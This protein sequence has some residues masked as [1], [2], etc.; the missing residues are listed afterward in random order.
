MYGNQSWEF[1]CAYWGS[2]SEEKSEGFKRWSFWRQT[3]S[4]ALVFGKL[5][6]Q[7]CLQFLY[8]VSWTGVFLDWKLKTVCN[9]VGKSLLNTKIKNKNELTCFYY[10]NTNE[11]LSELSH[12][13][14]IWKHVI[15]TCENI[16]VACFL[17]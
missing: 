12:E 2:K 16:T 17:P 3:H 8:L 14:L 15:F 10:I 13:N 6:L 7:W 9:V 1:A 11:I 5:S 4:Q